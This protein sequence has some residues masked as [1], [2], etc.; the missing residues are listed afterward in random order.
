M[1]AKIPG[2]D[3]LGFLLAV[4]PWWLGSAEFGG[5]FPRG[6]QGI[7]YI[8]TESMVDVNDGKWHHLAGV[9]DGAKVCLYV[10]GI[11]VDF[12]TRGGNTVAYNDPAYIGGEE[13]HSKKHWNGLIDDVRIYSY[14]LSPEEVKM[15]Y[16]GKEP[17]RERRSE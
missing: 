14:A 11:L 9:H 12:E 13:P 7:R 16:E 1:K 6:E 2:E 15:L 3:F 8:W 5:T 10:D 4:N 17:P